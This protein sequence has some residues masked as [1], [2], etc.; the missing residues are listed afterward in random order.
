MKKL[1]QINLPSEKGTYLLC[2][3][4]PYSKII[5]IGKI[6][7]ISFKRGY[8]YYIGKAFGKGGFKG[9]ILRHLNKSTKKRWH[10]DYLKIF[11]K[12]KFIVLFPFLNIECKLADIL[13][14]YFEFVNGF[15]A[16]DCKCKS[17]LFY[18]K[19]RGDIPLFSIILHQFQSF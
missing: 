3:F 15:G 10:I 9:R 12:I 11:C 14:D 8:Y 19:K 7:K 2:L 6:G 17:H 16:T 5:Q 13:K 18:T 1:N 4:L